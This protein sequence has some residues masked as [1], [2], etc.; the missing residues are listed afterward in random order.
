MLDNLHT[1]RL[2]L[3]GVQYYLRDSQQGEE[4]VLLLHGW[5]DDG[6]VWHQQI[7]ALIEAG[8]RVICPDLPGY[9]LSEAPPEIERY[10]LTNLVKD[11][12]TLLEKLNLNKV[13][14]I[15]HDYGAVLGW[16]L[17][18]DTELLN[19]YTAMSVGH[20]A[21]FLTISLENLQLQWVYFLNIQDIAPQLYL[22]NNGYLFREVLR[23]HPYGDRIVE[24]ALKSAM[25][26][27]MQ[28]IEKANPVPEYLLAASTGQLPEPK[29]IN[30]PTLGIWSERD[31][32]LWESQMK[33]SGKYISQEW[34]YIS[35]EQAGHWLMLEQPD[36]TNQLLLSWLKKHSS[37]VMSNE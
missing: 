31:E 10:Q 4:T 16:Q 24:N 17:A 6:T 11:L 25:W 37:R 14:C 23:S 9:G 13:H 1:S 15:A 30:V 21:E 28:R 22:A 5:P 8:Y 36:R 19:T 33:N 27:N 35:I 18:T 29:L 2:Q 20:L 34:Q 12:V 3:N 7:P 26:K 32:F